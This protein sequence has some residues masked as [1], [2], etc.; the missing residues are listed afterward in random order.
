MGSWPSATGP[1]HND[2]GRA[3]SWAR[4]SAI[5]CV[6][7]NARGAGVPRAEEDQFPVVDTERWGKKPVDKRCRF[8]IKKWKLGSN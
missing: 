4:A 1:G 3:N 6:F 8:K 5:S 7:N 2:I